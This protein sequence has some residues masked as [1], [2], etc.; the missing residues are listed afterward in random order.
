MVHGCVHACACLREGAVTST[1]DHC[2]Y[3]RACVCVH[4]W[5]VILRQEVACVSKCVESLVSC[6]IPK[7]SQ[8]TSANS[9]ST[10]S[11]G[12]HVH[13]PDFV[14]KGRFDRLTTE[15]KSGKLTDV[16]ANII[17][18]AFKRT[19]S[20]FEKVCLRIMRMV[21][22]CRGVSVRVNL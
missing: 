13:E 8:T 12:P 18:G 19:L 7:V 10:V 20:D 17:L 16:Q 6:C 21:G 3:A 5:E 4:V 2:V 22:S 15:R 14:S 1:R 11:Q 9:A